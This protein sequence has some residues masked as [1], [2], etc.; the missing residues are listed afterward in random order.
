MVSDV[1]V[2]FQPT[3]DLFNS[4]TMVE[5]EMSISENEAT[6]DHTITGQNEITFGSAELSELTTVA[7]TLRS[8]IVEP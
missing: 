8:K 5:G 6:G 3:F 7:N 1:H 2:L 4:L